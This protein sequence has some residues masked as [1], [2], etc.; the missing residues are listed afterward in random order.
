MYESLSSTLSSENALDAVCNTIVETYQYQKGS[1]GSG[2]P[3][4]PID[5]LSKVIL[6][7]DENGKVNSVNLSDATNGKITTNVNSSKTKFSA[8]FN[9]VNQYIDTKK[10]YLL[11]TPFL[12]IVKEFLMAIFMI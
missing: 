7:F 3:S 12:F 1:L 6:N 10:A 11:D 4:N 2:V 5:D 8:S 9:D